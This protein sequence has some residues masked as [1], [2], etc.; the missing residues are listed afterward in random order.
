MLV[1]SRFHGADNIYR[2]YI[3]AGKRPIMHDL[4]D[5]RT[6]GSDL[7]GKIG[8]TARPV[9]NDRDEAPESP[10]GDK[11]PFDH[12]AQYVGIDITATK[13]KHA[14][15]AGKLFQLAGKTGGQR[16]SGRAFHNA[17][18]QFHDSQNRDS[19]LLFRNGNGLVDEGPRNLE[20]IGADLWDSEAISQ[21]GMERDP[22]RLASFNGG[23]EAGHVLRFD[24]DYLDLR[25]Q[26]FDREGNTGE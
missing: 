9:A 19:D 6:G 24:S 2:R 23:G 8:Q 26:S 21:R 14:L 7:G 10:I 1:V 11:T 13:Q 12:A 18:F 4:L 20:G 22:G 16:G 15:F 3:R 25:P 17:L 5:A